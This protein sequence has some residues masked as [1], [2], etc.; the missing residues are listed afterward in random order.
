[1]GDADLD[2]EQLLA[3]IHSL[4]EA[5]AVIRNLVARVNDRQE[6]VEGFGRILGEIQTIVGREGHYFNELPAVVKAMVSQVSG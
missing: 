1:M 3:G 4:D 6:H 5:A 2:V